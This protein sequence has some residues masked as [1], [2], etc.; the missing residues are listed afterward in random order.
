MSFRA[1][2]PVLLFAVGAG[3]RAGAG[4]PQPAPAAWCA[5]DTSHLD[6][7]MSAFRLGNTRALFGGR[8]SLRAAVREKVHLPYVDPASIVRETDERVCERAIRAVA[9]QVWRP[10]GGG[11]PRLEP[12]VVFRAGPRLVVAPHFVEGEMSYAVILDAATYRKLIV[13]ML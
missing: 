6:S 11:R 4:A 2:F 5:R 12:V 3:A 1:S 10:D 13:T 7:A 8:D 9:A